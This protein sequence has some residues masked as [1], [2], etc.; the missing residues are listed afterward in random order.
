MNLIRQKE[1]RKLWLAQVV[2][3]FG[4]GVTDLAIVVL[5]ALGSDQAWMVGCVLFAQLLPTSVLGP[6]FGPLADRLPRKRLMVCADLYR[7]CVVLAMIPA[8]RHPMVLIVLVALHGLGTALFAPARS[9][10]I[11]QVVGE[12]HVAEAQAISQSTWSAMRIAGPAVGGTLL[13]LHNVPLIFILDACTFVLSA[14]LIAT[15]HVGNAADV[16]AAEKETGN[17]PGYDAEKE[18][19]LDALRSGVRHVVQ[20]PA[21]RFLLLLFIPVTLAAGVFNTTYNVVLLQV[22]QVPKVHFG[23]MESAFAAG[24]IVGALFAPAV[25]KRVRPST[26][27]MATCGLLG[28][29]FIAVLALNQLQLFFGLVPIYAWAMVTGILNALVNIPVSSL[30]ITIT[31]A[32]FRGR[33]AALL[34][35]AVNLGSM[36]G[37]LS[38]GWLSAAF[39]ALTATSVSGLMLVMTA[40][41]FPWLK[42]YRALHAVPSRQRKDRRSQD[43][44]GKDGYRQRDRRQDG[45][46]KDDPP[47]NWTLSQTGENAHVETET[48]P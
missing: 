7:V 6:F 17:E 10:V 45:R 9:A 13:A 46:G 3:Q 35:A 22:F 2:S 31:P 29:S 20:V 42:G 40:V 38:G 25:L 34:Q 16:V 36:A 39:G 33:G 18:S 48:T 26:T 41:T 32:E 28:I 30:F 44:R 1:F 47:M 5:V 19:Y 12:A 4:D 14:V 11:P 24:T 43:D 21:L 37:V 15:L 27:L 8:A 23:L